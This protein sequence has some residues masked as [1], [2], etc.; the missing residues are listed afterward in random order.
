MSHALTTV[1]HS[2][3][4]VISGCWSLAFLLCLAAP[5]A[6]Q[7][8][9]ARANAYFEEAKTLCERD[10]GKLWG[11]ALCGPMVFADASTRTRAT[12]LKAPEGPA[13][14]T[15][16]Y[17]NA[18]V[19]WGDA[20]WAAYVWSMLPHDDASARGRMLIHELFHRVQPQLGLMLVGP[21]SSHLESVEGRYWMQL[22]WRAL[23]RALASKGAERNEA[24]RDALAFRAA[25]RSRFPEA[26]ENE[27]VDELREGL[28]QYTG[29]AIAFLR[30]EEAIRDGIRQLGEAAKASGFV[31]AFSYASGTAYGLLLDEWAPG[32]TR[33]LRPG[34]DLGI[35][36]TQATPVSHDSA[37]ADQAALRYGAIQLRAAEEERR[38]REEARVAEL[39]KRFVDGPVV[40]VPRGRGA[41]ISTVG[42]TSIPGHGTVFFSYRVSAEW[43][44]LEANG[45]LESVDG[46]TLRLPASFRV[47]DDRLVG[48][49]WTIQTAPGWGLA[50]GSRGG[51]F[52]LARR[53]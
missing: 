38:T 28:A 26:G 39:K 44:S 53:K 13:P 17:V 52:E 7:V 9:E 50:P 5:A 43:G 8:E 18:P 3:R 4:P 40:I 21:Q 30:R 23:A 37:I 19:K 35:L 24:A 45:V 11:V 41:V 36:L 32:W 22:E 14:P 46:A 12:N 34:D 31:R 2:P 10:A 15:L 25:R 20:Y 49:G 48:E 33:R 16:G 6:G 29:T 42:V 47:E 51:D 27:R 1:S